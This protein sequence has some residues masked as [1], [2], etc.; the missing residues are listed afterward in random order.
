MAIDFSK[1][2]KQIDLDGLKKDIGEAKENNREYREVPHDTYVVKIEQ[3][4]L[5]ESKKGDPM[6][7]VWFKIVEGEY[8]NSMLFMNQ[9]I[10]QGFQV[11]IVNEFLRSLECDSHEVSFEGYSQYADLLLDIHEAIDGNF[12]YSVEYGD[13]KGFSTFKVNEV[14]ELD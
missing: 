7:S 6:V 2:D 5:K 12:E 13:N 11:H 10:T 3:M 9:V 14:F 8:K 1:F 4:E